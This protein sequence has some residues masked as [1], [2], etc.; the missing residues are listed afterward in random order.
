MKKILLVALILLSAHSTTLPASSQ[1]AKDKAAAEALLDSDLK[2]IRAKMKERDFPVCLNLL[3]KYLQTHPKSVIAYMW[4]AQIYEILDKYPQALLDYTSAI[5]LEPKF[6]AAYYHRSQ[7]YRKM[8]YTEKAKADLAKISFLTQKGAVIK[9]ADLEDRIE[10][11][12]QDNERL[13][14]ETTGLQLFR[15][16]RAAGLANDQK[17]A[18]QLWNQVIPIMD[19]DFAKLKD[20]EQE[21]A[22]KSVAYYN[23]AYCLLTSYRYKEALADLNKAI[24]IEPDYSDAL[25]NRAKLYDMFKRPDLSK[26]DWAKVAKLEKLEKSQRP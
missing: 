17:T 10:K 2:A 12:H 3:N 11:A 5:N 13:V 6:G 9:G 4:R 24:E 22:M 20:P 16:A 7:V 26:P 1:T 8:N 23:R 15:K 25:R 14:S 18:F 19:R 21:K